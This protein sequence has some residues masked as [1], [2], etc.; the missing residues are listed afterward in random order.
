MDAGSP[1][2]CDHWVPLVVLSYTI[3]VLG[4]YCSLQW[5]GQIPHSKGWRLALWLSG[6]SLAMGGGA[7]WSM[8]FIAMLACRLPVRV[9]YDV[10]LTLA[11]L[12]VAILVTGVGLATV[13]VGRPR[14]PKLLAGGAF[15]GLGGAGM[16]YTGMAAMRLP[17]QTKYSPAL[18]LGSVLVAI[19]AGTAALWI[20][21]NM[22][23]ALQRLASSL[24]MGVA[25]CSMHYPGL[26][27]PHI[28]PTA[29]AG[30]R[31]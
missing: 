29:A 15:T 14:V 25:V 12:L 9:A 3:S 30:P 27:A 5:A 26:A 2:Q 11:S 18:V 22:R 8:H 13:G 21:F 24:A 28:V 10:R 20:A 1:F 16:H 31:S 23:G 7:I 6:A 17:A 4:A 19:L